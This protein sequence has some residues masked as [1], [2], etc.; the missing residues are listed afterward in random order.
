MLYS[1]W[2]IEKIWGVWT[3]VYQIKVRK[4]Y[5]ERHCRRVTQRLILNETSVRPCE[6]Q[7]IIPV[8]VYLGGNGATQGKTPNKGHRYTEIHP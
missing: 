3:Q 1:I 7:L 4:S 6:G 2:G 5:I 8:L